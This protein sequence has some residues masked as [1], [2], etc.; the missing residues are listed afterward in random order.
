MKTDRSDAS[1][2]VPPTEIDIDFPVRLANYDNGGSLDVSQLQQ[3]FQLL[4]WAHLARPVNLVPFAHKGKKIT[5]E[6]N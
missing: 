2:A 6:L 1:R 4:R 3:P 5:H